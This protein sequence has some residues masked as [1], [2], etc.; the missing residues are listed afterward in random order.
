MK[1]EFVNPFLESIVK[2]ISTMANTQAT[3]GRPFLKQEA[4]AKGDVTGLIGLA[5]Q[6]T[7]GSLAIT[8][9]EPA[10]LHI[11]SQMLGETFTTINNDVADTVGEITNMVTGGAKKLLAEK[12]YK[13]DLAIPSI[14]VGKGHMVS[15]KTKGPIVIVPFETVAGSFFVEI[16]FEK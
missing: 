11:A 9:T 12:G 16:C 8:F 7:K 14:I 4:S 5:G 10:I 15:H 13:F 3:P 1:V 2:V 6:Q